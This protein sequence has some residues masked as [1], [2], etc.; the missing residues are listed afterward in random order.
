MIGGD[1][2]GVA[3]LEFSQDSFMKSIS[4]GGDDNDE[5]GGNA[6]VSDLITEE[7]YR[8]DNNDEENANLD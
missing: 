7:I 6:M 8:N 1:G 5:R 2:G 3:G 4:R